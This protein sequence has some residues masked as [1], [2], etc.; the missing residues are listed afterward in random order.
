MKKSVC[1][2][3]I[4]LF[5]CSGQTKSPV[6]HVALVNNNRSVHFSGLD[7][8]IMGEIGRD[9]TLNVWENLIPV[10]R[11]PADT[12]MKDFQPVQHGVYLLKDSVV[13]FTPDTP[14][15]KGQT[16]YI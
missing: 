15:V 13:T 14:F 9:T 6:V 8:S 11:M 10:Y 12:D 5:S 7:P 3:L 4:F 1:I 2:L 16:Y